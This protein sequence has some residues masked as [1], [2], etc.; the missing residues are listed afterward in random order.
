VKLFSKRVTSWTAVSVVSAAGMGLLGWW[1]R[2]RRSG[3]ATTGAER[4]PAVGRCPGG[5]S[6]RPRWGQVL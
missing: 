3:A 6:S 5:S 2:E 1:A 4:P